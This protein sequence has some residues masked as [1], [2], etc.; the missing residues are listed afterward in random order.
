MTRWLVVLAIAAGCASRD[1]RAPEQ[2][3]VT[4]RDVRGSAGHASHLGKIPCADCHGD[5]GFTPRCANDATPP[6]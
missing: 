4:Y 2:V 1:H 3:P 6:S 5:S